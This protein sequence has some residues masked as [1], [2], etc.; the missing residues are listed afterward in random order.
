MNLI[1][2]AGLDEPNSAGAAVCPSIVGGTFIP[3][4]PLGS[5]VLFARAPIGVPVLASGLLPKAQDAVGHDLNA[6]HQILLGESAVPASSAPAQPQGQLS[7]FLAQSRRRWLSED[8]AP[9]P[10]GSP[11]DTTA[12]AVAAGLPAY[13]VPMSPAVVGQRA[14]DAHTEPSTVVALVPGRQQ[15]MARLSSQETAV[16][17]TAVPMTAVPMTAVPPAGVPMPGVPLERPSVSPGLQAS[18]AAESQQR[19]DPYQVPRPLTFQPQWAQAAVPV[20]VTPSSSVP[21]PDVPLDQPP[22]RPGLQNSAAGAPLEAHREEDP[23]PRVTDNLPPAVGSAGTPSLMAS[24][25]AERPEPQAR[26]DLVALQ[27]VV[28]EVR[29]TLATRDLQALDAG[30]SIT[31]QLPSGCGPVAHLEVQGDGQGGLARITLIAS[32]AEAGV[33]LTRDLQQRPLSLDTLATDWRVAVRPEV[34]TSS[35]VSLDAASRTAPDTGAGPSGG[36][37]SQGQ[38]RRGSGQPDADDVVLALAREQRRVG[39]GLGARSELASAF[40]QRVLLGE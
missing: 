40:E 35:G 31:V 28:S 17:V 16:P 38:G 32:S 9:S 26:I 20:T 15:A 10:D 27:Q 8:E 7:E 18:T 24:S 6:F 33:Q 25:K 30:R 22:V 2:A 36:Y 19:L 3:Q 11:A 23:S 1:A 34:G 21:M 12:L 37:G 4:P 13:A 39:A 5:G 29:R 14:A